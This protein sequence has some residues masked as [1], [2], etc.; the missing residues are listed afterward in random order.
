MAFGQPAKKRQLPGQPGMSATSPGA[1]QGAGKQGGS[2]WVNLQ[3]Y[4]GVN[5]E[6]GANAANAVAGGVAG[7]GQ[8][9]RDAIGGAEKQFGAQ[10]ESDATGGASPT[11][12]SMA[13]T[14]G[15][16]ALAKQTADASRDAQNL[17]GGFDRRQDVVSQTLGKGSD[18]YSGGMGRWDN[19]AAGNNDQ[20]QF[21]KVA[22]D[23]GGLDK[24]L[25]GAVSDSA[26]ASTAYEGQKAWRE[27]QER[28]R[29]AREQEAE[30]ARLAANQARV[31]R[32]KAEVE[33]QQRNAGKRGTGVQDV[34]EEKRAA[35]YGYDV[36]WDWREAGQPPF[37]EWY[38]A[39]QKKINDAGF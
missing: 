26:T 15:F 33:R 1:P 27:E 29:L 14:E 22:S 12:N 36:L 21:G 37:D 23:Y 6:Q 16:G 17:G 13:D 28:Q 2:G 39:R 30:A 19:L 5:K 20:G 8:E 11:F 3:T 25:A 10:L 4:L 24:V 9:A 31:D 38:A 32:E 34:T 35:A 7:K 18:N